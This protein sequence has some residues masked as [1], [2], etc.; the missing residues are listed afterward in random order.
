MQK[1]SVSDIFPREQPQTFSVELEC[2]K[3]G[4]SYPANALN[5]DGISGYRMT[6]L[7]EKRRPVFG[8][9]KVTSN[10]IEGT[11]QI[12]SSIFF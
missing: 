1:N 6:K 10:D 4:E 2:N 3:V 12:T 9:I 5:F 11:W 8:A 7:V